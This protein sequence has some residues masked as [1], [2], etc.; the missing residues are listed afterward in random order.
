MSKSIT[1]NFSLIYS[2]LF[3]FL[4]GAPQALA[5]PAPVAAVRLENPL[6]V[7][8]I[9]ELLTAILNILIVLAIPVIVFFIIYSGFLY[10]T[11]KG[12]AQQVEQATRSLT[13][14]IIGGVIVIGAVAIAEIVRNLV[15][16]F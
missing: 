9:P 4:F 14:A 11:A 15:T 10:V 16:S 6:N 1:K 5:Q 12:N 2:S 7:D 3:L 13:Y 8:T